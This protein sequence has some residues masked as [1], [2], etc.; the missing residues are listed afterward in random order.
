VLGGPAFTAL[1][2]A[3]AFVQ[4]YLISDVHSLRK[5]AVAA[6]AR[7]LARSEGLPGVKVEVQNVHRDTTA[8]N[9][10]AAGIGPSR[11]VLLWDTVLDG[12]FSLKQ[13]RVLIAHEFGHL[14]RNH[15]L[16]GVLWFALFALPGAYLVAAATRRRGGMY[17]ARS[18]PLALFVVIV[19]QIVMLPV[20]NVISRRVESE[21]DW[22]ALQTTR[23][24]G[25]ARALF[26]RLATTSLTQP[27]PPTW[28]YIWLDDHPTIIQR[29]AMAN[30]W[31]SRH[32]TA[33]RR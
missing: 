7:K 19:L 33:L 16:K 28:S 2:L 31:Q 14:S 8:P 32:R 9:A 11:R 29:I 13:L 24:P 15:I 5:P 25:S 4:P 6:E 17:D 27:R 21:A 3:F 26:Q 12:R 20:Q 22:V 23:D 1:A 30:A 10:E 18:V